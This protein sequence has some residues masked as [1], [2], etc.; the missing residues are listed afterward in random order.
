MTF[1]EI[2][3]LQMYQAVAAVCDQLEHAEAIVKLPDFEAVLR[4]FQALRL[5]H[6]SAEA[7]EPKM[8]EELFLEGDLCLER[9]D[10]LSCELVAEFPAFVRAFDVARLIGHRVVTLQVPP[11][12]S[13]PIPGAGGVPERG[14]GRKANAARAPKGGKG[15]GV[16]G[17]AL[18]RHRLPAAPAVSPAGEGLT[19]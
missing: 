3:K 1:R 4:S 13:S 18:G 10:E 14:R 16:R 5:P 6:P 9:M 2:A 15:S 12:A 8:L 17:K 19:A 7:V 11:V